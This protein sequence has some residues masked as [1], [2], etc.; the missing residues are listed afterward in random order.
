MVDRKLKMTSAALLPSLSVGVADCGL[1]SYFMIDRDI[2][3]NGVAD[4]P[5]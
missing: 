4:F 2:A 5:L 1:L 3:V